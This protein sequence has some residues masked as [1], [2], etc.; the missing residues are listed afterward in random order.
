VKHMIKNQQNRKALKIKMSQALKEEVEALSTQM[1]D[2]LI[3]DLV[4]AF[5]SRFAVL[6]KVQSNLE[7]TVEVGVKVSQ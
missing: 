5:E 3:D 6:N 1:Q 2:I 7:C 4:T